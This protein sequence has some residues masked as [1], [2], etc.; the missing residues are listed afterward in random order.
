MSAH[1]LSNLILQKS[2]VNHDESQ[3]QHHQYF[4]IS[5]MNIYHESCSYLIHHI[6]TLVN[7]VYECVVSGEA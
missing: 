7:I 4:L 5:N 1:E 3:Q 6:P 2:L